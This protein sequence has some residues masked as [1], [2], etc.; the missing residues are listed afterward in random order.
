MI[1]SIGVEIMGLS[2]DLARGSA[3][4]ANRQGSLVIED[5]I[6]RLD[7]T[8]LVK[9]ATPY[10]FNTSVNRSTLFGAA[11]LSSISQIEDTIVMGGIQVENMEKD[12]SGNPKT[13][14][15]V[16]RYSYA[17]ETNL[18]ATQVEFCRFGPQFQPLFTST[19]PAHP[20]YAQ[21][22]VACL[23]EIRN[24]A[25]NGAEMGAFNSQQVDRREAN[26]MRMLPDFL[27]VGQNLGIFTVT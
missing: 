26:L 20:G 13:E 15:V 25:S 7:V 2:P 10:D 5:S 18:P 4:A 3:I 19:H 12:Q 16:L 17:A 14:K 9:T 21:L 27:P 1:E 24:G 22:R 8:T 23:K 6:V 11:H